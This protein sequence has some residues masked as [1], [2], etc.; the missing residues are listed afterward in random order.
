LHTHNTLFGDLKPPVSALNYVRLY[1][2]FIKIISKNHKKGKL[3]L[4]NTNRTVMTEENFIMPF[5]LCQF[6]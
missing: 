5:L 1:P 2:T 3:L 4:L 6:A